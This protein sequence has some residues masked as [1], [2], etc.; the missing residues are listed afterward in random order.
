MLLQVDQSAIFNNY[1]PLDLLRKDLVQDLLHLYPEF[2]L[3]VLKVGSHNVDALQID[4]RVPGVT[5]VAISA[6]I[7]GREG[8]YFDLSLG[9]LKLFGVKDVEDGAGIMDGWEWEFVVVPVHD[10]EVL[11]HIM[12]GLCERNVF[13]SFEVVYHV[14]SSHVLM[15]YLQRNHHQWNLPFQSENLIEGMRIKIDIEFSCRS[16]ITFANSSSHHHDFYNLLLYFRVGKEKDAQ[17][18]KRTSIRPND[19]TVMSHN[20]LIDPLKASLSAG[21]LW[22]SW[23]MY[24]SQPIR[25]VHV[26]SQFHLT[27]D[28]RI[29][30]SKYR[31]ISSADVVKHVKSI[32][33]CVGK[34]CIS[35]GG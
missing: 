24:A 7:R 16:D 21:F 6:A 14:L 23:Q 17:V 30:A 2:G 18:G 1:A 12:D 13:V 8:I 15:G 22:R 10:L 20:P 35:R 31:N 27:L 28:K 3:F 9:C 33:G 32:L 25:S 29:R 11:E 19:V 34:A 4:L 26:L 5:E